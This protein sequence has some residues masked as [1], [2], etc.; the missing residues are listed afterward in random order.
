MRQALG[1]GGVTIAISMVL[2]LVFGSA[3]GGRMEFFA[4]WPIL[5]II[6]GLALLARRLFR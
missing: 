1:A 5:L 6:G 3:L 4:Y 2:F